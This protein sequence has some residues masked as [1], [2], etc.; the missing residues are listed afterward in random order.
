MLVKHA[1]AKVAKYLYS[2][3][4]G[5]RALILNFDKKCI[6]GAVLIAIK[7]SFLRLS[8]LLHFVTFLHLEA[9]LYSKLA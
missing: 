8:C 9:N 3:L 6:F 1:D 7:D 2:V 4:I 5:T